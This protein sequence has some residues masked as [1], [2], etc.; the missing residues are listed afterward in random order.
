MYN[1]KWGVILKSTN[2][3]RIVLKIQ[4]TALAYALYSLLLSCVDLELL[5][6]KLAQ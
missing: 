6:V 5:K 1:K 3:K 2:F 4:R